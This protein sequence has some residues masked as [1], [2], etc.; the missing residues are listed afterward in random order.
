MFGNINRIKGATAH[1]E[2]EVVHHQDQHHY[3]IRCQVNDDGST[4]RSYAS[5]ETI[6]AHLKEFNGL[7]EEI[8]DGNSLKITRNGVLIQ[9][10]LRTPSGGTHSKYDTVICACLYTLLGNEFSGYEH[11]YSII[12]GEVSE[13]DD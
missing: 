3:H 11:N 9:D 12:N 1:G 4:M 10:G 2:C 8:R 7:Y 6:E 5:N 13:S